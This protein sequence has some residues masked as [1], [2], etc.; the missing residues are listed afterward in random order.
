MQESAASDVDADVIDSAPIGAVGIE[1]DEVSVSQ[2]V[3]SDCPAGS[4]LV[5]CC[6]GKPE[7]HRGIAVVNKSGTIETMGSLPGI[8]IGVA[9]C[10]PEDSLECFS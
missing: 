7:I 5:K 9:V 10:S 2:G 3:G 1:E 4:G 8:A 6:P